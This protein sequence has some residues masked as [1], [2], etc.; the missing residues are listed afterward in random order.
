MRYMIDLSATTTMVVGPARQVRDKDGK[1]QADRETGEILWSLP[2]VV[3]SGTEAAVVQVKV[4]G[5][6]PAVAPQT[7]VR[8]PGLSIR[9]YAFDGNKGV[10]F[11]ADAVEPLV[12]ARAGRES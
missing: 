10:A 3:M 7:P 9:D 5:E 1:A 12:P 4:A 8:L 11:R 6:P 2:V